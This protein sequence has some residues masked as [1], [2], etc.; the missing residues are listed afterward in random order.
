M[1]LDLQLRV[2]VS[3][4][5]GIEAI[6]LS[7]QKKGAGLNASFVDRRCEALVEW[8]QQYAFGKQPFVSLPIFLTHLSPFTQKVLTYLQKIPFGQT[9]TYG[10]IAEALGAKGAARAVGN[11]CRIN[12]LPLV[13]PCHRVIEASGKLGGFAYGLKLKQKLLSY[14]QNGL[15]QLG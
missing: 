6:F 7:E 3:E 10:S 2:K 12:P 5:G 14:E 13:I 9:M 8:L 1:S 11:A 4:K 15:A